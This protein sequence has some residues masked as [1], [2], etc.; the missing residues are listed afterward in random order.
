LPR[1]ELLTV[2]EVADELRISRSTFDD[3]RAKGRAPKCIT[4]PNG[5]LRIRRSELSR[6]VA[7]CEENL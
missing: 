1:D 2:V 5:K 7:S 6:F 3:W 4:L